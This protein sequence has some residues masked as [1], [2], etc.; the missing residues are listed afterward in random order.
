MRIGLIGHHV[1]P[2]VAPFAGGVEAMTW[3]LARW[4]AGRGHEVVLYGA[5]GSH[6]PGVEIRALDLR[7]PI[8][9]LAR[10]DVSM[11]P[12]RFMDAHYAYQRLMVELIADNDGFDVVHSHSLHYLPVAMSELLTT[13]MLLTL[14]CP[15]T[16]WL[17]AALRTAGPR[18]PQLAAVSRA[19]ARMWLG[20]ARVDAIV[21]NGVDLETWLPGPGGASLAWCG[22][23]VPEKAPHLAVDAAQRAGR[24]IRLAGPIIDRRYFDGELAPRL[25]PGADYVGHL[26]HHE[27]RML[28]GG[29]GALLQTPV[30]D[31]PFGLTAAEAMATG[32]PVVSFGR[33]GLP[34]LIG[35]HG[36][37][38]VAPGDVAGLARAATESDGLSRAGVRLHAERTLSIDRMGHAYER[39]YTRLAGVRGLREPT[40]RISPDEDPLIGAP[41]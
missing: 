26:R 6:V 19:T 2:T 13:P 9:K 1:A 34:E 36:G 18:G 25:G 30:W 33:G 10:A 16:P 39:L 14:H 5:P 8:S 31:E 32:T 23:V 17:E 28:L 24:P 15:P 11:P 12:A 21:P 29:S 35:E 3:Y 22:R 37:L 41:A 4:L 7:P 27:L 20:S 38:V 40:P